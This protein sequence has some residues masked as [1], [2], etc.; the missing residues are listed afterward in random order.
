MKDLIEKNLR[1]LNQLTKKE[2]DFIEHV[3]S[4]DNEQSVAFKLAK[5]I[6]EDYQITN[7]SETR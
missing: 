7:E 2:A 4:W 3:L 6:F 1:Y 5:R